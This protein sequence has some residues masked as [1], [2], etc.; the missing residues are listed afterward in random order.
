MYVRDHWIWWGCGETNEI[1]L[2][3]ICEKSYR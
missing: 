3:L 1:A 2:A